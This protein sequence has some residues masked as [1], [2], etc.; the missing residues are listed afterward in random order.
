MQIVMYR[1]Q[2]E[3]AQRMDVESNYRTKAQVAASTLRAA[4]QGGELAP[5]QRIDLEALGGRLS[6]SATP[7][8]EA[9]R[10][11]EAEGLVVGEPHRGVR[12]ADFSATD[13]AALYDLR[14]LLEP[15]AVRLGTAQ[16]SDSQIKEMERL[17]RLHRAALTRRDAVAANQLNQDWHFQ[18]Y[19]AAA[20]GSPY[21]L[22]FISKLWS[23]FPWTTAWM[24]PGRD[25]RS[26]HDHAEIMAAIKDRDADR[27]SELMF[28]HVLAGKGLVIQRLRETLE[29]REDRDLRSDGG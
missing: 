23:A 19:R 8:R 26:A 5:G 1:R 2:D 14:A 24:V 18:I 11:L 28:R 17:A 12:V 9:L 27:A 13:A 15:Y 29:P 20:A 22:D 25:V 3:L 4:I 6:M 10:L 7:I 16:L 21:L